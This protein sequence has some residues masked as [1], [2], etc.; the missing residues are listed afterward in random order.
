LLLFS[1]ISLFFLAI[2]MHFYTGT[3]VKP[4]ECGLVFG[5]VVHGLDTPGPGIRR[6]VE[7]ASE[8][9]RNG[10]IQKL[11]MTGGQGRAGQSSEAVV[12]KDVAIAFGVPKDS[13]FTEEIAAST[14]E[15][16]KFTNDL[17]RQQGCTSV[18][19]FS[20]RYH[21]ARIAFAGYLQ[22]VSKFQ[23]QPAESSSSQLFEARML[24]RELM[25]FWY[26]SVRYILFGWL[27][28]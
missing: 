21:L 25:G 7:I 10:V 9:Y 17:L 11:F 18:V 15:N 14:W 19:A 12:M 24:V 27:Y 13:I 2:I 20:D 3:T 23:L 4:S 22:D 26:Y 5:T 8:A 6:R 1:V 28:T 16:I